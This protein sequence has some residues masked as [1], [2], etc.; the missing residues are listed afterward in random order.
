MRKIHV[1]HVLNSAHGG[2]AL[3]TFQLI[4]ELKR[5]GVESSLVCFN[6]ATIKQKEII[7][8]LVAGRVIF[9]P[10]YWT[11]KRI[12]AK[13]WKRPLLE[14]YTLLRT[15]GG[16][17]FQGQIRSL[18]KAYGINIVHTSTLVNPEGAIAAALNNLPHV[19]HVRELV[20]PRKHFQFYNYPK[21]SAYI[22]KNSDILV[23]NSAATKQCLLEFFDE[24]IITTIP[25]GINVHKFNVKQH[26]SKK[27]LVIGMVGS[28]TSQ[29][30]NHQFF[31][32][33]AAMSEHS[34]IE[35]RIYG[36]LPSETDLYYKG[37]KKHIEEKKISNIRF[38]GFYANPAN[39][40]TEIDILFHPTHL[41]SFGRIFIEALAG[42]I[43]VIAINQGGA[44]EMIK[45]HET[46]FLIPLN[47]RTAAASEIRKLQDADL[48]NAIGLKARK[49][50]ED[51]YSLEILT[52]RVCDVYQLVLRKS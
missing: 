42:G 39:I 10:L 26:T 51:E 9:I 49:L 12:R 5:A 20:G 18:I 40:M 31:I 36:A 34:A 41:E 4:E 44:L 8:G 35:F 30:K 50:V 46:G 47:D 16:Y 7:R 27:S 11:N 25:N 17:R 1:L 13:W 3:S 21:W 48:R 43:P 28:V 32:E 19:W 33:T 6:N 22:S 14:L 23:A 52:K 2:S 37:L 24:T 29:W 15:F 38:M 45:H